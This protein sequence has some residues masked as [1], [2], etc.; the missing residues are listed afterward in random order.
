MDLK[1][2]DS[3]YLEI[4]DKEK[5]LKEQLK[6][7]ELNSDIFFDGVFLFIVSIFVMGWLIVFSLT[8]L[9]DINYSIGLIFVSFLISISFVFA[10]TRKK[11]RYFDEKFK[12]VTDEINA[13]ETK[14]DNLKV[15]FDKQLRGNI[16][17]YFEDIKDMDANGEI[18]EL[19]KDFV[20][21][22]LK[23]KKNFIEKNYSVS[24]EIKKISE[25][26]ETEKE[27]ITIT[28]N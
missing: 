16:T 22:V 15:K 14:R 6:E 17:Q 9:L 24:D 19:S 25:M 26:E 4:K 21:V 7:N 11:I 3:M 5:I 23:Y 28:N 20:N 2:L 1:K 27:K 8:S 10:L 18:K 12:K 13:L